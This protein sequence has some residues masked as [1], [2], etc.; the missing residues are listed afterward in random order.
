MADW[1]QE[2]R[3]SQEDNIVPGAR[4]PNGMLSSGWNRKNFIA[5]AVHFSA[6]RSIYTV[7]ITSQHQQIR[8]TSR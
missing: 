8:L 7:S 2:P 5:H 1:P 6:W 3:G 4:P